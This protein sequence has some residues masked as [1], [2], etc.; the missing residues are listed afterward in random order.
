M[1]HKS[2]K[3]R[4]LA[5]IAPLL[6]WAMASHGE[7]S[8]TTGFTLIK[9]SADTKKIYVSSSSGNN[10]NNC[11]TPETPCQTIGAGLAKMRNGYPDHLYLKRG[12]VWRDQRMQNLHSGRSE[13]EPAVISY[14]GT[15]GARPK[16]ENSATA[17]HIF[18]GKMT[19][20]HFIG[21]EFA[22]YK[23]DPKNPDFTGA[24]PANVVLLGGNENVLFED[25]KFNLTEVVVQI[26]NNEPPKN[27]QFRR[28]IWNGSYYNT[29]SLDRNKR[30][31]N[32]YADGVDGLLIE[33]NVFDHGG[34]HRT[35]ANA[36]ANMFNH[37]IYIQYTTKAHNLI[38]RNN[39]I[40]RGSSHGA[41][42]R[43][44]GLAENN[45]FGRNAVGLII[46]KPAVEGVRAHAINNVVSEGHSMVKGDKACT[47][48]GLCT[49]AV[50]GIEFNLSGTAD[51]QAHGNI[52]SKLAHNDTAWTKKYPILVR[53]ALAGMNG[54]N[55]KSSNNIAWKWDSDTQGTDKNY[56]APG[57]SLGG[58]YKS[59]GG[60][61]D[62]DGFM[63]VV[64][65][66]SPGT[67]NKKYTAAAINDYIRAG[68]VQ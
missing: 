59:I 61:N 60:T 24:A 1:Q 68:F 27:I 15:S 54:A 29:S 43:P 46:G 53:Q 28:N 20:F 9:A 16:I 6:F 48:S 49:A 14:Y 12:D 38:L 51:Y 64:L 45:F 4:S 22:A 37:N 32:L 67:W 26:W 39:I 66:R 58:Y 17:L 57:R 5:F 50:W 19:N 56:P 21:L 25:V 52:V 65:N 40:T 35:I 36:G 42:L 23:M 13:S 55:L 8:S 63:N 47:G 10:S 2:P 30:P 11:L 34:W 44:G 41:Q 62:F 3:K 31:S 33:E 7:I 18:K